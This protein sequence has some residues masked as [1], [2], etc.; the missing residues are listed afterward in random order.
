MSEG[1]QILLVDDSPI[2]LN[3]Y[4]SFLRTTPARLHEARTAAAALELATQVKPQL[5]YMALDLP[6][7]SGIACC[8]ALRA[9]SA[10]R[11]TPV[12]LICDRDSPAQREECAAAGGSA[13]LVRPLDRVTFLDTG[14]RFLFGIREVRRPCLVTVHCLNPSRTFSAR[15]LDLCSGGIFLECAEQLPLNEPLRLEVQL[16]RPGGN[17][18]WITCSGEVAWI[19]G[20]GHIFKPSHPIGFGIRFTDMSIADSGLLADFLE[21]LLR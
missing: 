21:T 16:C 15:G 2:F 13:V 7:G 4:K 17:A 18:P 1:S 10:T 20:R 14:A 8:R 19:N 6:D 12:I 3:I 9:G 5:I 11:S